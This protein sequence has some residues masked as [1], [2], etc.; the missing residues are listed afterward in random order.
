MTR[1]AVSSIISHTSRQLNIVI[2]SRQINPQI[3]PGRSAL[4]S[5]AEFSESRT[6]PKAADG[7]VEKSPERRNYIATPARLIKISRSSC[8]CALIHPEPE[9]CILRL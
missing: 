5:R 3:M 8:E 2:R 1:D 7:N 6:S 4:S 9:R